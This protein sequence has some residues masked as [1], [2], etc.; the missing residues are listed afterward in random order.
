MRHRKLQLKFVWL[1]VF[2]AGMSFFS[3]AQVSLTIE[4]ALDIAE[5]NNPQ[6]KTSKLN[7]QRTQY[8]LEAS[9]LAL[10]PQFSMNV[11]PISYNQRRSFVP[12]DSY[13]FTNKT[14]SS[15]GTFQTVLPILLTDGVFTLTNEFGWQDSEAIRQTTTV[16]KS[17][18]N[19]L[20]LRYRQPI[21]TYN[22]RKMEIERLRFNHENS[23]IS[24]ALQ[25]LRTEQSITNQ[26][27]AVYRAQ[28][29]LEISLA[30]FDNA[31]KNY[32]IIKDK[33]DAQL[34]AK[35]ELFQ[36]E[37]NLANTE[38]NVKTRDVA[39]QSAKDNLK[40]TLGMPLDEEINVL[41]EVIVSPM[42]VDPA[43]AIQSGLASRMEL[44]QREIS[45]AQYDLDII[46][47]KARNEFRGN[48]DLAVGIMGD[49]KQFGNI[50]ETPTQSPSVSITFSIPI[51]DW[52]Q[53]KARVKAQKTSQTIAQL[54]YDNTKIDIELDIRQSLRRLDNFRFQIGLAETTVRNAEMTYA[55]NEIRYREGDLTGLQMSQYQS[56]LSSAKISIVNA[57]IDYKN[58]LLNLKILTLYDF[59]NDKPIIPVR[60]LQ[61]IMMR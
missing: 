23:G 54:E 11:S 45:I 8:S 48:I 43:K 56:Q 9:R 6:M 28:N 47:L 60:E 16:N 18:T 21:F 3:H 32:D 46:E 2:L 35:E 61:N 31:K 50:Y 41:V 22:T 20:R 15:G 14:L 53:N 25:R 19:D 7:Y 39:L 59:E 24:Y 55:L 58:E 30:E 1:V 40:Q 29:S 12:Q 27:Y 36:A 49:N 38:S 42:L 44:R 52:G 57:Q 51:F 37:L 13:W 10:K 26:F 4:Q 33:V 5:E 34:S 17:F